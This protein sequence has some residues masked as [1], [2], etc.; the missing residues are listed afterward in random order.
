MVRVHL[1]PSLTWSHF[2]RKTND[3]LRTNPH[4]RIG[5]NR[6]PWVEIHRFNMSSYLNLSP[7]GTRN[8]YFPLLND[9]G[10]SSLQMMTVMDMNLNTLISDEIVL[11]NHAYRLEQ[12]GEHFFLPILNGKCNN[13]VL[14][15][16]WVDIETLGLFDNGNGCSQ[17]CPAGPPG[18]RGMPGSPGSDGSQGPP[19]PPGEKG[20]RGYSDYI[21]L[22]GAVG[23]YSCRPRNIYHFATSYYTRYKNK[24]KDDCNKYNCD[25]IIEWTRKSLTRTITGWDIGTLSTRNLCQQNTDMKAKIVWE[26]SYDYF[27]NSSVPGKINS[28]DRFIFL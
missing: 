28:C 24:I 19:G 10:R 15:T 16:N 17:T 25:I 3:T 6:V 4:R 14:N 20:P 18:P 7:N 1:S 12:F 23:Q 22:F 21:P 2:E 8:V 11:N 5:S 26:K 9:D 13:K 27:A